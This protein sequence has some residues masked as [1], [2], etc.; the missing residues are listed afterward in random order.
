MKLLNLIR[1]SILVVLLVIVW[2]KEPW[3]LDLL[4]TAICVSIEVLANEIRRLTAYILMRH[5][6]PQPPGQSNAASHNV[7]PNK[8]RR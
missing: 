2:I 5:R 6:Y 4:L 7:S 3:S 1:V 8:N